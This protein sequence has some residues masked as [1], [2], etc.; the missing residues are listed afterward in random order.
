MCMHVHVYAC[1]HVC[2]CMDVSVWM[3]LWL[4]RE[5][6]YNVCVYVTQRICTGKRTFI[7]II[8]WN[9][10]HNHH[11]WILLVY[12]LLMDVSVWMCLW[13]CREI[14]YN[15]CVYVTQRICTGKR[16]FIII[17]AWNAAHNH[18]SWILLVYILLMDVSVWMCLWLCR[19]I[20]YNV[21]VY[22]TQRICTGKR[23][24][25]IIIA[26]NAA[27]NHHSWILL[28]YTIVVTFQGHRGLNAIMEFFYF[29]VV[30]LIL[31]HLKSCCLCV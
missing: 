19:E 31:S 15:V 21:C 30:D 7:I 8:A 13:L 3:C 2:V 16:T 5:I 6:L 28:V 18:H 22:V 9:A 4:C 11:S 17:I 27:H 10:A 24:F 25:I 14:L 29:S 23:T 1:T 12:I 26:W 20:L